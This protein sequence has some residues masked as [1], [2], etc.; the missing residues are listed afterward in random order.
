M[1]SRLIAGD[2]RAR[3]TTR[4]GRSTPAPRS[5]ES[6]IGR[7][8]GALARLVLGEDAEAAALAAT[9]SPA[10]DSIPPAVA[11]SLAAL[12]AG[13][14]PA[15]EAAIRALVADFEARDEFL[16]DI[17]VADTVLALQARG[18]AARSRDRGRAQRSRLP[19][20]GYGSPA[21]SSRAAPSRPE[22]RSGTRRARRPSRARGSRRSSFRR[23]T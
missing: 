3:A 16:E 21:A 4:G 15:Y 19:R 22:S 18:D 13:D 1:K 10:R 17:P 11:D 12:A 9:R 20:S 5:S 14:G 7:Y 23:A 8:A 6:P 2:S